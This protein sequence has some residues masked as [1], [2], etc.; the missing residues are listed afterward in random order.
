MAG[1]GRAQNG[2]VHVVQCALAHSSRWGT[3]SAAR[4]GARWGGRI[5]DIARWALRTFAWPSDFRS[6][7]RAG[8]ESVGK[9]GRDHFSFPKCVTTSSLSAWFH[10]PRSSHLWPPRSS[11]SSMKRCTALSCLGCGGSAATLLD[12]PMGQWGNG[13][14]PNL[15]F[16][17]EARSHNKQGKGRPIASRSAL[18][19][20]PNVTKAR[21]EGGR[22]VQ[23]NITASVNGIERKVVVV[24][25]GGAAALGYRSG[26]DG[27]EQEV[28]GEVPEGAQGVPAAS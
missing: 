4:Y 18:R 16:C 2:R 28:G 1:E 10:R 8:T 22:V 6:R 9:C 23:V 19:K 7:M 24:P 26:R 14:F 11:L 3:V 17:S 15:L 5:L 12:W 21:K 25:L 20:S 13:A 27:V